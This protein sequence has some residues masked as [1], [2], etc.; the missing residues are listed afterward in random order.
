M[1]ERGAATPAAGDL[2]VGAIPAAA[3]AIPGVPFGADP[4]D[5]RQSLPFEL[6]GDATGDEAQR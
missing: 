2:D 1:V 6:G 3:E 4:A 5:L